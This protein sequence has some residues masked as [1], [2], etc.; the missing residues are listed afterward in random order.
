LR[1]AS[2]IAAADRIETAAATKRILFLEGNVDGTVGGSQRVLL[3]VVAHLDRTRFDPVVLFYEDHVL[4]P[5]FRKLAPVII[6]P[7]GSL[8]I[9]EQY[10]NFYR[11]VA[12]VAPFRWLVLA[13]QKIYNF[14]RYV[15]PWF[16]RIAALL[17]RERIDLVCL[18]NAPVLTDWLLACKLLRRK[19]VSY[20]RGTPTLSNRFTWSY[21]YYDAI[22][23]ISEAVT[24]NA[25][26]QGAQV[27][28]FVL[29]YDGIDAGAVQA[30]VSKPR[31]Q[32]RREF[33]AGN[34]RP[35]IGVVNNLKHW[36]GQHVAIEAMRLLH[37]RRPDV[38]CLLIGDVGATDKEYAD[39]LR[40][41]VER[42]GLSA[43]VVFTGRRLDVPDLLLAL[44]LVMHTSLSNEGFPRVIL[45]TMILGR[46]MIASSA[47]PN[48]EMLEH[49]VSGFIVPPGDPAALADSIE[50]ALA[51][52]TALAQVGVRARQ[53][54]ERLFN[55]DINMRKTEDVFSRLLDVP[56]R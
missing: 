53:R 47:G 8:R 26:Q 12:R 30:K 5:E 31:E 32:T 38:L 21:P 4:V 50:R 43:N 49:G 11:Q 3:E 46:P 42:H 22:L 29:I 55:I 19:C 54:A 7:S 27:D 20:F 17:I 45:E 6:M 35:L 52:R 16:F 37:A 36:K 14:L 44:D 15:V 18:N 23:S 33:V 13:L 2:S 48:V 9:V 56:A 1:L 24:T 39:E 41:S 40:A 34:E 28:N 25:R 10:P 51:D